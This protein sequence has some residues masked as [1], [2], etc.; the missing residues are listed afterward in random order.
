MAKLV[1][2][3]INQAD[4]DN[5]KS[6]NWNLCYAQKVNDAYTVGQSISNYLPSARISW[7]PTYSV[8][9]TNFFNPGA[10]AVV[11]TNPV[12]IDFGQRA[13]LDAAGVLK[14]AE[15]IGSSGVITFLNNYGP[16][17]PGLKGTSAGPDG[18]EGQL[19][20]HV[21]REASETGYVWLAPV[22]V[23]R[24]WFQ[25]TSTTGAMLSPDFTIPNQNSII[26]NTV[27]AAIEVDLTDADTATVQ[28]QNGAW[29]TIPA[30]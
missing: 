6:I 18:V 13:I 29:S 27:S 4:Y 26:I 9:G 12:P 28:F 7:L 8:F 10:E 3:Q 11:E 20:I 15:D 24:I 22:D 23:L 19:P 2:I 14:P 30:D 16:I 25:Q 21:E 5:F 17:H 1:Q